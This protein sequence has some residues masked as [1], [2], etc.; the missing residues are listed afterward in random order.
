MPELTQNPSLS[1]LQTYVE[2]L[3]KE[4]SWDQT[5]V[6]ETFLLFTEEVGEL[7]K[8]IRNKRKLHTEKGKVSNSFELADE[9]ADVL[10]YLLE[11][12]NKFDIDLEQAFRKKEEINA[13][14]SW[15]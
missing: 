9:L 12:A 13:G 8:A 5:P 3:C 6:L 1:E 2:S 15:S 14:R 11:L 7:A 10:S 4:R